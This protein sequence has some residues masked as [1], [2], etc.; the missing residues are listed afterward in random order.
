[1]KKLVLPLFL[2]A[3]LASPSLADIKGCYERTYDAAHLKK[4]KGQ[5]VVMMRLQVGLAKDQSSDQADT[6]WAKFRNGRTLATYPLECSENHRCFVE[7]DGGSF[8]IDETGDGVKITNEGYI[9]FGD[10]EDYIEIP[11]DAEHRVFV[12]KKVGD[13]CK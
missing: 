11:D 7:A 8:H 5:K 2:L 9:R 4:H 6:L 10:D 1:M 12:L 3:G 13:T